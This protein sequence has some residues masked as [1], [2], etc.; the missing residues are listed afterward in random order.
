MTQDTGTARTRYPHVVVVGDVILDRDVVGR[1]D[2]IAPDAPVP[3]L[4]V[5]SERETAGGA[6]LAALLAASSKARVSLIAPIARDAGGTTLRA[7]LEP[8]LDLI[9]IG[10]QGPTRR[11]TRVRSGGQSLLRIDDGGPGLPMVIP[12]ER[13]RATLAAADVVL[14]ADYGAGTTDRPA[15]PRGVGSCRRAGPH[16]LGPPSP[17]RRAGAPVLAG[18]TQPGR[19]HHRGSR[20]LRRRGRRSAP[21]CSPG[22]CAPR[23]RWTPSA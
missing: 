10:H 18:D 7:L 14:V 4:D 1:T 8:H 13:I 9:P 5:T 2:R 15:D 6:G 17:G 16:G 22:G 11:K 3:V 12:D 21:T 23:G 20:T 19:G